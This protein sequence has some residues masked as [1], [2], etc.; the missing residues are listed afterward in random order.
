VI[1]I[2][3]DSPLYLNVGD[4]FNDPGATAQD[5]PDG[6][7]STSIQT[8]SNVDTSLAGNYTVTYSVTDSDGNTASASRTVI[9]SDPGADI[10]YED[11]ED[12]NTDGW[13]VF[14]NNPAGATITNLYD[15]DKESYVI[16]LSGSGLDNMYILRKA[17]GSY[18]GNRTNEIIEWTMKY[19]EPF[20]ID[21]KAETLQGTRHFIYTNAA[22][23][24]L[25]TGIYVRFGLSETAIDGT[26]RIFS[27]NLSDDLETAQPGNKLIS[28]EDFRI[29]GSGRIDD[30]KTSGQH[31]YTPLTRVGYIKRSSEDAAILGD[32]EAIQYIE[33]NNEFAI[34]DDVKHQLYGLDLATSQV[35]WIIHDYDFG[36]YTQA[37]PNGYEPL[38]LTCQRDSATGGFIGFCDP[39]AI[40]YDSLNDDLYLFTG[41]HP[42]ELTT[43]RLSRNAPDQNFEISGWKR[44]EREHPSA[45]F[46]N[47][48]LYVTIIDTVS[49]EGKIASY[50]WETKTMGNVIFTIGHTIEDMAYS[51]GIL[52][53][54]T[55]PNMLYKI[56]FSD[57]RILDSYDMQ[58]YDINDPRGVEV[59]GDKLYIGDGDDLRTDDLLHAI[60]IFELP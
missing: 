25:G 54:L 45:I 38:N 17:D 40:A 30:I 7:L 2:L 3:G 23:D 49:D 12:G 18:W 41:N 16:D 15:T 31:S 36:A 50:N 47:N 37:N 52:W 51:N 27:R 14:D 29:R 20:E 33:P 26:W 21:I 11:A 43:F 19:N 48:Q 57:M 42:G 56:S 60:H 1:T 32:S 34:V 9:V 58:A 55:A 53:L 5:T 10:L 59:I 6:D 44:T 28:I 39:E 8:N 24:A 4:T 22:S 35:A 13:S 46:I